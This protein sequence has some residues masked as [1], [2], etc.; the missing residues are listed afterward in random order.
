MTLTKGLS[1]HCKL[2]ILYHHFLYDSVTR[3]KYL[4]PVTIECMF[5]TQ[6]GNIEFYKV[7]CFIGLEGRLHG[8]NLKWK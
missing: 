1:Q 3:N 2:Y 7:F 8:K 6:Y 4:F 5:M